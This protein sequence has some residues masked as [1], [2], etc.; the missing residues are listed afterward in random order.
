[1]RRNLQSLMVVIVVVLLPLFWLFRPVFGLPA[2]FALEDCRRVALT[3]IG[4]GRP[5][6]GV[7]DMALLPDGDTLILSAMDRLVRP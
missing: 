1:M 6:V 2:R 7:E 5:I 4:S 3:D